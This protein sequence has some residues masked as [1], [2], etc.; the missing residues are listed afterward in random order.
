[1][2]E[3][4]TVT[5]RTLSNAQHGLQRSVQMKHVVA[6]LT[7]GACLLLSSPGV[8]FAANPH[9]PGTSGQLGTTGTGG[10]NQGVASCGGS[11]VGGPI[12]QPSPPGQ[13]GNTNT[14]SP[15][16]TGVPSGIGGSPNSPPNYAGAAA[17]PGSETNTHANSQYDNACLHQVK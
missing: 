10:A 12:A 5:Q 13:V 4:K 14:N 2:L 11:M 9:P 17:N 16:P 7:I 1:M 15:F 6:S 8:V 3:L